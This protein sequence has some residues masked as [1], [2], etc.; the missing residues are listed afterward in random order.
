M[1]A[2]TYQAHRLVENYKLIQFT[3]TVLICSVV[4]LYIFFYTK[5]YIPYIQRGFQ[6]Q[7]IYIILYIIIKK[8]DMYKF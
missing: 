3:L 5:L 7:N 6:F 1:T 2:S 8:S 4:S